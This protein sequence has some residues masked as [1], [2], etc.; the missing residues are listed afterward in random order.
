MRILTVFLTVM[1]VLA[2]GLPGCSN[3]DAS[4]KTSDQQTAQ[5]K[6]AAQPEVGSEEYYE[7]LA[8]KTK[9]V[10]DEN[11]KIV[12]LDV[13]YGTDSTLGKLVL[14]LWRDVAPAHADSFLARVQD[15]FYEGTIFHRVIDNFMIQGGDPK[16]NGSGGADYNL[17]AEFSEWPHEEG[18]LSMARARSP[19]SASSQF[20]VMLARRPGLDNQYTV[21]GQLL[22]GYD[23]LHRI[24][25]VEC[26]ANP[27]NPNEVSK[28]VED[29]Y[30]RKAYLSDAEGNP[31]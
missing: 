5:Q 16:G 25:K 12:T 21:F 26:V 29:I 18:T 10:R 1:L 20:F 6:Q 13:D 23:V 19:N 22:K 31:L 27:M 8:A 15:G 9:S 3:D 30:L 24:G 28:P 17:A 4:E 2:F 7:A 14:E 11:N